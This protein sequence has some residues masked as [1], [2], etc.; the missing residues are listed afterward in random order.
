MSIGIYMYQFFSERIACIFMILKSELV[1]YSQLK[2]VFDVDII[3][4]VPADSQGAQ[5]SS[6]CVYSC[7]EYYMSIAIVKRLRLLLCW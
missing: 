4:I 6:A 3:C 1:E 5:T 2:L 7:E